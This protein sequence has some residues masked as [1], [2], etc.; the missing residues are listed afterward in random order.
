MN[1]N[2]INKNKMNTVKK[3]LTISAILFEGIN[4]SAQKIG[5]NTETPA[6]GTT[7]HLDTHGDTFGTNN[8]LD[9][10]VFT[11]GGQLGIGIINPDANAKVEV[12][13]SFKMTGGASED[14]IMM[15]DHKGNAS[16]Q[17]F[18]LGDFNTEFEIKFIFPE[19]YAN[20]TYV[21]TGD[22]TLNT[23][24]LDLTTNGSS[25]ITV[26]EGRY[27]MALE[28]NID[29]INEYG[30]VQLWN[31]TDDEETFHAIYGIHQNGIAIYL[32]LNKPTTFHVQFTPIDAYTNGLTYIA[33][34]PYS[35][36]DGGDLTG[37]LKLNIVRIQG[38]WD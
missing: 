33:P 14:Y 34:L 31:E 30:K 36:S 32:D 17:V 24:Q 7:L 5:I 4:V 21:A 18:A 13:G 16:W 28:S 6:E 25:N 22:V 1:I 2:K 23:N 10:V 37:S 19:V 20:Q 15:S 27:L 12:N 29:V 9:D 8:T 38:S 35:R 3:I 26:P 11:E